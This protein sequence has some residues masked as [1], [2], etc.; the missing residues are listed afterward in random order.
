MIKTEMPSGTLY[1]NDRDRDQIVMVG[2]QSFTL[3]PG[4]EKFVNKSEDVTSTA[5]QIRRGGQGR[6]GR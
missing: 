2:S 6:W 5:R 4:E 1:K 3:K